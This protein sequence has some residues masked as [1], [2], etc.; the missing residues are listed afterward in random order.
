MKALKAYEEVAEFIASANPSKVLAFRP[1]EESK[2]RVSELI[3]REKN[4]AIDR[5]SGI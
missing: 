3:K 5:Q 4:N 1:S 2:Q